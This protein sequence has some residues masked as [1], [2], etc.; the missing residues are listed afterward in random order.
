MK[1][2]KEGQILKFDCYGSI[3]T[4]K[5]LK[6]VDGVIGITVLSDSSG[7]FQKGDFETVGQ[8]FLLDED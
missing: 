6:M 8:N 4:G 2:F 7:V 1:N 5:Y 3:I